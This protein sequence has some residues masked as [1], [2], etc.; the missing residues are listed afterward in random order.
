MQE[1]TRALQYSLSEPNQ[2]SVSLRS[3][4]IL[5]SLL[6]LG[7]PKRFF[8]VSL[9]V[10]ILKALLPSAILVTWPANLNLLDFVTL[11]VFSKHY[12]LWISSMWFPQKSPF[13]TMFGPNIFLRILFLNTLSLQSSFNARDHISQPYN[14]TSNIIVLNSLILNSFE[15]S[16]EDKSVFAGNNN[17]HFLPYYIVLCWWGSHC[18]PMHCE[19]FKICCASPNLDITWTWICR[20]NSAQRPIFSGWYLRLG[21]PS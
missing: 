14:A 13:W 1:S 10:E 20:L 17:M 11:T 4:L 15:R 7:L 19:L 16:L 21:P 8:P 18:S 5:S 12:K 6:R 3:I 9:P 2:S